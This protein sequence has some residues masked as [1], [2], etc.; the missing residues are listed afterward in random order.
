M[1]DRNRR[2][3]K[4]EK[5]DRKEKKPALVLTGK[6]QMT[7]EGYI[8]VIVDGE[9]NDVFVKAS[10]TR[11]A[12]NGDIVKVSVTRE[13]TQKQRREGV[14]VEIVERA[15]K[16]FIG[17]LHIV[18]EQAWVLMESRT[19][20]YDI[21]IPLIGTSPVG[22]KNRKQ[23][24]NQSA[25]PEEMPDTTGFLK[26]TGD[27]MYDVI[28]VFETVDNVRRELRARAGMKVAALVDHWR[29]TNRHLSVTSWTCSASQVK[30]TPRCTPYLRNTRS[31]TDSSR[32]W[33]TLPTKF[34]NR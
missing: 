33:K 12:L 14:V 2:R 18:G 4:S 17:I 11:G 20:P 34:Q 16:P 32:R 8:F 24:I 22:F 30:T 29:R 7:R 31:R 19:M 28:G 9:D 1:A 26:K 21:V 5:K 3:S 6:V 23:R 10:K 27:D 13:K 15:R 25:N